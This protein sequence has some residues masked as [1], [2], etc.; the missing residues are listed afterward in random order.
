MGEES[1]IRKEEEEAQK[2][3]F[4]IR[5]QRF[6]EMRQIIR[7]LSLGKE[8]AGDDAS[9]GMKVAAKTKATSELREVFK[10]P[11]YHPFVT[12]ER[13]SKKVQCCCWWFENTYTS[14]LARRHNAGDWFPGIT[15]HP[16]LNGQA[17]CKDNQ[18]HCRPTIPSAESRYRKSG[19]SSCRHLIF[20]NTLTYVKL[21]SHCVGHDMLRHGIEMARKMGCGTIEVC[22]PTL[23]MC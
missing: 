13:K 7:L 16:F 6:D 19:S 2:G 1:T 15:T 3:P 21:L 20:A 18:H 22:L 23:H 17:H 12:I 8:N 10:S 9:E 4:V 11:F 5:N 14:H